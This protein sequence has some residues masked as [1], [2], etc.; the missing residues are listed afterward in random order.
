MVIFGEVLIQVLGLG[1]NKHHLGV[2]HG[3]QSVMIQLVNIL[4]VLFKMVLFGHQLIRQ[5]HSI[6]HKHFMMV[7]IFGHQSVVVRT[8]QNLRQWFRV[9]LFTH[10][11]ILGILG[12]KEQQICFGIQSV[13]IRTA[14]NL[15]HVLV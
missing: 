15:R 5:L 4:L 1:M 14:Q 13:V 10:L 8:A 12:P 9:V 3:F 11:S 6:I 2:E 7:L